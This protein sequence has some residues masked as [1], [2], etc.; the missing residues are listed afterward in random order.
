MYNH[1]NYIPPLIQ[2]LV[3]QTFKDFEVHF[4][5]DGSDDGTQ[6]LMEALKYQPGLPFPV[7]YYRQEN[8]GMR[9]SKNVNQGIK[10]ANGEY[11]VFIMADSF[12]ETTYL[13][14]FNQFVASNRILCGVRYQIDNGVGVDIEWRLKKMVIP[15][16][17]VLLPSKPQDM[18]TGNG[19][20]IPTEAMKIH[21]GWDEK[22]EGYGGDDQEIVGRLYYKGYT[23]WS[24]V[25]AKLYH[26]WHKPTPDKEGNL[27]YIKEK[28]ANYY[29]DGL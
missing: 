2:T 25:D 16:H 1:K 27:A 20:V 26:Y 3:N 21:G 14:V 19:M 28:L 17:N 18:I 22:I 24:I 8:K 9:L 11:C 12:P 23:V 15:P 13:E 4:C 5:D 10:K 6:E 7:Y 29:H